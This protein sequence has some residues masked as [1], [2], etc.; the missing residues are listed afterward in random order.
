MTENFARVLSILHQQ[1]RISAGLKNNGYGTLRWD[2]A[3]PR[4]MTLTDLPDYLAV[5]AGDTVFTTGFSNLYPTRQVIGTVE[6]SEI[7][8][9]T[10]SQR[11]TVRLSEDP[12]RTNAVFVVQDLFK[13]ELSPPQYQVNYGRIRLT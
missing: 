4:Y 6:S 13:E 8:P 5:A 7:Q 2:G 11:L 1:T 9:G 3:D 12:L 10:G